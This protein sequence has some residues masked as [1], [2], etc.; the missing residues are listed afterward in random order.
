MGMLGALNARPS[1]TSL[2]IETLYEPIIRNCR[3]QQLENT[4][5][6][7]G[8]FTS[9]AIHKVRYSLPHYAI[10]FILSFFKCYEL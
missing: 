8:A 1:L 6:S 2:R 5:H 10:S 9:N 3:S 4:E 7:I